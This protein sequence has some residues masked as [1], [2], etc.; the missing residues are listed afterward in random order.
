MKYANRLT[1]EELTE[2]YSLF[3]D[4]DGKINKLNIT[5]DDRSIGLCGIV[6]IPEYEKELLEEDPNA[7]IFI[8]DD[9]DITDYDVA[10]YHHSGNCTS[11][12]RK[13]MY[14]KFG[15]EYAKDYLFQ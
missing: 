14:E 7:T 2:L 5:R 9:Y 13:W 6:E 8:D 1:D 10:V 3:T 4:P 15:D 12:Y 11:I